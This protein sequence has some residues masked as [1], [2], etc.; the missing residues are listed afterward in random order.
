MNIAAIQPG[1]WNFDAGRTS[2]IAAALIAFSVAASWLL[3]SPAQWALWAAV[4][5][6]IVIVIPLIWREGYTWVI[7]WIAPIAAFDPVPTEG[8]R[9]AKYLVVFLVILVPILKRRL[10]PETTVRVDFKPLWPAVALMVWI[11]IRALTGD[12]PVAGAFEAMRLSMVAAVVY[13]WL[14]DRERDGGRKRWYSVWMI[15]G[16][17][18]V[19]ACLVE[20]TIYGHLRSYGTFTNANS[21]G[22]YLFLAIAIAMAVAIAAPSRRDR[23]WSHFVLFALLV[24]LYL[25]ASR[26]SWLATAVTAIVLTI[27]LRSW[28]FALIGVVGLCIGVTM[29]MSNPVFQFMTDSA[30]RIDTGLTHRPIIWEA[31]DRARE[32][33]PIWGF[34]I[35]AAGPEMAREASYPSSVHR[36]IIADVVQYGSPHNFYRE[37]HLETGIIGVAIFVCMIAMLL[38]HSWRGRGSPDPWRR[39]YSITLFGVIVG[40]LVHSMFER[41]VFLGSMSSAI[42]FWFLVAQS[43]RPEDPRYR[44]ST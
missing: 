8:L 30:L 39:I 27:T 12:A 31:A 28:R 25:T 22:A 16:L 3:P 11:W 37:L 29:Y 35:D 23:F 19:A 10:A 32:H 2:S 6:A 38:I 41:S 15:M 20:A 40:V 36:E 4:G 21:L 44:L 13:L 1:A 43:L 14:S 33:V 9:I 26:A 42:F 18:Q 5:I 34:G 24:A 7:L 17:F